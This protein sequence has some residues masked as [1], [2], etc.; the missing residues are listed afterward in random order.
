MFATLCVIVV[1]CMFMYSRKDV[2]ATYC[3]TDFATHFCTVAYY[4]NSCTYSA[5]AL[6]AVAPS[7]R[8]DW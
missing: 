7:S 8:I 6:A 1:T 4:V 3:E 5:K 2:F